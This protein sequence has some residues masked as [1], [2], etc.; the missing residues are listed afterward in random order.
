MTTSNTMSKK[1]VQVD[2]KSCLFDKW[3]YFSVNGAR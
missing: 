1:N 3:H 2:E